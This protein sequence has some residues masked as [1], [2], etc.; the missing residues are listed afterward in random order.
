MAPGL[1]S[2]YNPRF[3]D[4]TLEDRMPAST[5]VS[6]SRDGRRP[7]WFPTAMVASALALALSL[8]APIRALARPPVEL[9]ETVPVESGLGNPTLASAHDVWVEMI[10]GAQQSLD[11]EQFYLS[12][13]PGEP[14]RDVL[15]AIGAAAK[16]GVRVRL[17]LDARMYKTY[18][19]PAD[20]LGTLGN[21]EV[22]LIDIGRIAGGVQHSK[23][24]IVDGTTVF[25]GS[26]NFDWRSL[27]HIQELGVR[28]RDARV[29]KVFAQAFEL[30]WSQAEKPTAAARD[31]TR[32]PAGTPEDSTVVK[33]RAAARSR[34][35]A[36]AKAMTPPAVRWPV[37]IV[38]APGDTVMLRASYSPRGYIPDSTL[39]DRDAIVRLLDSARREIVVQTLTYGVEEG[40][41]KDATLDDALRRAAGRGVR[42][43]LLISDWEKD[44][45]QRIQAL[46][47]L[48]AV[49]NIEIKLGTVPEWSGGYVPFARVEHCKYAVVDTAE[50][51][52]GTSNWEPGYFSGSRNLAVTMKNR[53]IAAQARRIFA[54][55]WSAPGAEAFRADATYAP[56]KHGMDPPEGKTAYGK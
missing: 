54:T 53:P 14:M 1:S 19:Q 30:D 34:A 37:A 21:L 32:R 49:P 15:D 17:M 39:W 23:H 7:S 11:I 41:E 46:K 18:P 50:T 26:Q 20:S 12:D 44:R 22:R 4:A 8:S 27:K 42:V 3:P 40:R 55:S 43:Q 10:R 25:L 45:A 56:K 48:S 36:A 29:A 9:A 16:R 13:W 51:W 28:V 24:F 38:Q 2:A 35:R 31:T 47:D 5:P 6:I 33:A 52:V